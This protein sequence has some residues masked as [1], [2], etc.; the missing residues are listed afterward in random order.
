MVVGVRVS[1]SDCLSIAGVETGQAI[2][3][4]F[5]AFSEWGRKKKGPEAS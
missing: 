2:F 1:S 4:G 5:E 3:K